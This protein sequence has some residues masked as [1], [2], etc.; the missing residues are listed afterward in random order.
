M[1]IAIIGGTGL[2]GQACLKQ[3]L[4]CTD[5]EK[6]YSLSRR[7]LGFHDEKLEERIDP[8]FN[9]DA[10]CKGLKVDAG[11]SCFGTTMKRA[12][13]REQFEAID[14][15][16]PLH[17]ARCLKKEGTSRFFVV[18]S[19]G[20]SKLSGN[21]YLRTKGQ[22]EQ[23]LAR[24]GFESLHIFRPALLLGERAESRFGESLAGFLLGGLGPLFPSWLLNYRPVPAQRVAESIVQNLLHEEE[25]GV[26][27][28]ENAVFHRG[29]RMQKQGHG[30]GFY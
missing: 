24:L 30:P 18:S 29:F 20:A 28:W 8:N 27:F 10:M 7:P 5:V 14:R 17:F 22:L 12:K 21:F 19:I 9:L 6:I 11:I 1:K 2:I 13:S 23:E 3:L 16:L 25:K 15:D 4:Q 26:Q